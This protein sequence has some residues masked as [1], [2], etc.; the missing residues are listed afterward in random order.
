[1][2]RSVMGILVGTGRDG[3]MSPMHTV[4][5]NASPYNGLPSVGSTTSPSSPISHRCVQRLPMH[6]VQ[7][8]PPPISLYGIRTPHLLSQ[9]SALTSPGILLLPPPHPGNTRLQVTGGSLLPPGRW[10]GLAAG[11]MEKD[12]HRLYSARNHD[13]YHLPRRPR[14]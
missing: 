13:T 8:S 1:M 4:C 10:Y 7:A 3:W 11:R 2:C 12:L 14:R 9:A 6:R 5:R